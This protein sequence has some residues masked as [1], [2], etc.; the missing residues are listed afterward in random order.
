MAHAKAEEHKVPFIAA[1]MAYHVRTAPGEDKTMLDDKE[2]R[3]Y[4]FHAYRRVAWPDWSSSRIFH[5]QR[6]VDIEHG[7]W[8]GDLALISDHEW[9]S[10]HLH[11]DVWF[12]NSRVSP[13][14]PL[15]EDLPESWQLRCANEELELACKRCV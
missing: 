6:V 2:V 13:Q 14:G 11:E 9:L 15:I 8:P 7:I 1:E 12:F 5:T 3:V 4:D 10:R